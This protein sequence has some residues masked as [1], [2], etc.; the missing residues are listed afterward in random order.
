[1][2]YPIRRLG[3]SL[4]TLF[5]VSVV[6]FAGVRALPG[7][8]ATALAGEEPTPEAIAQIRE[9]YGLDDN[10]VVQYVRYVRHAATGDL[11]VSSRTGLPVL[12]S[13]MEAL[14]VTLEL[15]ALA[16]LLAVVVGVGA[17]VVAAVRRGRPEEWLVN[18]V[19]LLGLSVP[20]FWLGIVLVLAFAIAVPVFAASGFVPFGVDP[21]ENLRHMVLPVIVL[22]SGLAAVVMRQTRAAMLGSLSADYVRTARAKGLSRRQVIMGHALR[23]SLVT[24]VTVL[25]LQLGHLISGAVVTEQIFV[26]PGFGKLTIDAVFSRDYAMVQ[27]VVLFTSTA[28]ILVN[29]LVDLAYS[30]IDPRIRL[31]GAQ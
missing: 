12:D 28:Y 22:G 14:P 23:N 16:L 15:S 8:T 19:A 11:G 2:S 13:V 5:L 4:I 6:V 29:L 9:S 21:M 17:G 27:G 24:V 10:I 18:A 30:V 20:A 3:E 26:L 7:D 31:G 25:G 1:M